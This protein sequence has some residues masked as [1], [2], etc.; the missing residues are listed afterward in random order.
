M[1]SRTVVRAGA[2]ALL[3]LVACGLFAQGLYYESVTSGGM[4]GDKKMPSS[5]YM[6]PKMFKH[7]SQ[8]EGDAVIIRMDQQM[9]YTVNPKEKT[10]T[11]M[12]FAEM[13]Q[14]MKQMSAKMDAQ[15]AQ[16]EESMKKMPPEQRKMMEGMMGSKMGKKGGDVVLAHTGETKK[17]SGLTCTKFMAKEGDKV[18]MTL[19]ATKEVRGFES[20]RKDYEALTQ[21]MMSMNP[22]FMK[23]L[24]DAMRQVDGFPM[25]T[26]WGGITMQVTKVEPRST[27]A[28]EFAVPA[29]YKKTASPMME[30]EHKD[31]APH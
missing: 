7:V 30:E 11:E 29:G 31:A 26:E 5:T 10:Y 20:L 24:M 15:M 17:V 6:M 23:G 3:T 9:M 1:R 25:E 2:L 16:M 22:G 8:P 27:S 19:W 14:R 12:T 18:L 4:M 21:R 28:S 13:E